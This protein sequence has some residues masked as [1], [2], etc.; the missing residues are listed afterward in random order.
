M[1]SFVVQN[2]AGTGALEFF[3]RTPLDM[4]LPIERFKV[5]LTGLDLSAVAR[6]YTGADGGHPAVMFA[7]M[8]AHWRGWQ[9]EF[10]WE[11]LDGELALRCVQDRTGHVA[12]GVVLRSG[13]SKADWM[14]EAT[15]VAEAGQ[16]EE[17]A[18]EAAR[19]FGQPG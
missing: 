2:T 9:G 19:F 12:I 5:R 17:I 7:Q 15:V 1:K 11:S 10:A 3:E 18:L 4:R 16:L 8:A 14:V 6:V 13:P